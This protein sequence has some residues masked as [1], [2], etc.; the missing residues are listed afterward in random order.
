MH[1]SPLSL[2]I[3]RTDWTV[4][5]KSSSCGEPYVFDVGFPDLLV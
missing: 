4:S 5:A 1:G 2:S 3:K